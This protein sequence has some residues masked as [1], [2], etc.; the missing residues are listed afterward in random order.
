[1]VSAVRV[2]NCRLVDLAH[3]YLTGSVPAVLVAALVDPPLGYFQCFVG[4]N[5]LDEPMPPSLIAACTD[6]QA[7]TLEPQN[8][9][10]CK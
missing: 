7:C 9:A 2:G 6:P 5:C 10:G 8:V 4:F 3:N 1:M